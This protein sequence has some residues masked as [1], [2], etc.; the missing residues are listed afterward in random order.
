MLR[1]AS[2]SGGLNVPVEHLHHLAFIDRYHCRHVPYLGAETFARA[3]AAAESEM[4][5]REIENAEIKL[6]SQGYEPGNRYLHE[7]LRDSGPSFALVRQW[8]G[9]R[10]GL[11]EPRREI[12]Q[13]RTLV[14]RAVAE[15]VSAGAEG[16]ARGLGTRAR[17]RMI[18]DAVH[19]SC[20]DALKLRPRDPRQLESAR[21]CLGNEMLLLRHSGYVRQNVTP[22]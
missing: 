5:L 1:A 8:A 19:K 7:L 22:R 15:L 3:L 21:L 9:S 6:R 14:R 13:L 2:R 10:G 11:E 12:R 20:C 4:V 18:R 16:S 17:R